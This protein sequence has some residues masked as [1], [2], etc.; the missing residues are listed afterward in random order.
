[1][2]VFNQKSCFHGWPR[3]EEE[4]VIPFSSRT[5]V[6]KHQVHI[7]FHFGPF[8]L[9]NFSWNWLK[10]TVL[11]ELLWEKKTVPA[12]KRSRTSWIW[13][14]PNEAEIARPT[15]L[16]HTKWPLI[17]RRTQVPYHSTSATIVTQP[18]YANQP[19]PLRQAM[20]MAHSFFFGIVPRH[21]FHYVEEKVLLQN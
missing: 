2:G 17:Q 11:T 21:V 8:G 3:K 18:S 6:K 13:G 14:K 9:L 20:C 4:E 15:I 19:M 16:T 7:D 5:Q 12:E 10:N 1:M